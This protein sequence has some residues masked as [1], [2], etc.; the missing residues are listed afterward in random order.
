MQGVGESSIMGGPI[1]NIGGIATGR[2]A[3]VFGLGPTRN[4]GRIA[5]N[6]AQ[7]GY[8]RLKASGTHAESRIERD[9]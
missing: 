8:L 6:L 7:S 2:K 4:N 1:R 5:S 3:P 9:D